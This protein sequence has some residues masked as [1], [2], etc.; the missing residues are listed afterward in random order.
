MTDPFAILGLPHQAWMDA[1]MARAAFQKR[2]AA[3]HPDAVSDPQEKAQRVAAFQELTEAFS[4]LTS[5][6]RRLK[7]LLE[8]LGAPLDRAMPL[9]EE[10]LAW[11]GK[12]QNGLQEADAFLAKKSAAT[13]PLAKALLTNDALA[14]EE[15]LSALATLLYTANANLENELKAMDAAG[16]VALENLQKA[17]Q[18][19]SFLEK[20]ERQVQQRRLQL[21]D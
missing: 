17:A 8:S 12:V 11:F 3:I 18:Q 4:I 5:T 16:E 2:G 19:A 21:V 6:P 14:C 7:S 9:G 10:L 20:W 13:S 15:K 1:E